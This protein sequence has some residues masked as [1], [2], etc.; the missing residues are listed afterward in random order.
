MFELSTNN[1]TFKKY[2]GK[3]FKDQ[4]GIINIVENIINSFLKMEVSLDYFG[5]FVIGNFPYYSSEVY[6]SNI[7]DFKIQG[8]LNFT[9]NIKV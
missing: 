1:F 3:S 8:S 2:L 4:F 6:R 7:L 5:G 9:F